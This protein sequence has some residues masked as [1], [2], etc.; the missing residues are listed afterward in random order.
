[1]K[2]KNVK[3]HIIMICV[4]LLLSLTGF[5]QENTQHVISA[6]FGPEINMNARN[7]FAGGLTLSADYQLPIPAFR[8]SAGLVISGSHNFSDTGVMETVGMF[9]WYFMG[10]DYT[11]FFAQAD[12]GMH[13]IT[14]PTI[15]PVLFQVGVRAGYRM[16]LTDMFYIEPYGRFGYPYFMG[17]GVLAGM[18]IQIQSNPSNRN[19]FNYTDS[20]INSNL[21]VDINDDSDSETDN[22]SRAEG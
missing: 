8:F 1:M 11:G 2:E 13:F 12:V 6:G 18:R 9:R 7:N 15:S 3:K 4:I 14:E 22:D 16:F 19:G 20:N 5:A 10:D 17:I 21:N